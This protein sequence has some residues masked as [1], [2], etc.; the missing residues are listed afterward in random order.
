RLADI[1]HLFNEACH[2]G[3]PEEWLWGREG[4]AAVETSGVVQDRVVDDLAQSGTSSATYRTP[5][6][7][8]QHAGGEAAQG[9]R[10][11]SCSQADGSTGSGT[12]G[13]ARERIGDTE[14]RTGGATELLGAILGLGLGRAAAR[15]EDDASRG[16]RSLLL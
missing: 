9:G 15:A 12:L 7:C 6:Q 16:M 13:S 5:G 14:A 3:S 10:L 4:M 1:G 8:A 11:G 2:E